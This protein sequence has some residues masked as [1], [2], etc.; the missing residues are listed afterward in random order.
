MREL[1]YH[2]GVPVPFITCWDQEVRAASSP[3]AAAPVQLVE[4]AGHFRVSYRDE[5]PYD[6]DAHGVLWQRYPLALGKGDP[7]FAKVHP[8]RQRRCMTRRL[9][10]VCG[11]SAAQDEHGWLWLLDASDADDVRSGA[12]RE[13]RTAN[14]PVCLRCADLARNLCPH[15]LQG[16][17]LVRA[18]TVTDWG[19]YGLMATPTGSTPGHTAAYGT[20]GAAR[21]LA[22]QQLVTLAHLT[23]ID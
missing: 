5:A 19:I 8:A 2:K 17:A 15:L 13:V 1:R 21:M 3:V 14:P 23:L 12:E 7:H 22:G 11:N 6:R 20:P 16:N 18:A 10:Q 4:A 9:C